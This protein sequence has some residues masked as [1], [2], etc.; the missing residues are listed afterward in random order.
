MCLRVLLAFAF[1]GDLM[2]LSAGAWGDAISIQNASFETTNPLI[3]PCAGTG[4][5]YNGGPIPGWTLTGNGGSFQPSS[6]YFN[7]PLPDGNIVAYSNG[8]SISQDL[9]VSLLADATYTL[10]VFV[11]DRLDNRTSNYSLSLLAGTTTL[12]TFSGSNAS[13]TPGT[14]ADET[15]TFQSGTTLPSGDLSI[16]LTSAGT[17]TDFDDVSLSVVSVPEPSSVVLLVVGL[18]SVG[19]FSRY[20]KIKQHA[21]HIC[22]S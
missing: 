18:L 8:G 1:V 4:C 16:V 15:C 6:L 20:L 5:A 9:G 13:I 10:S 22:A 21:Q 12:C 2:L 11:G 14:F 19:L 17:Q 7:L 3:S